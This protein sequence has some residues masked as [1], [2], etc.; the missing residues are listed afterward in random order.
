M[1]RDLHQR[2]RDAAGNLAL[3]AA[4]MLALIACALLARAAMGQEMTRAMSATQM[5][6]ACR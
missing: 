4:T 2:R 1:T 6:G 5:E 3:C